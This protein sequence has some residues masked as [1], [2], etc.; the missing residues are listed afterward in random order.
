MGRFVSRDTWTGN[1]ANSTSQNRYSYVGGNP[2]THVDPSGHC[3]VDTFADIAFVGYDLLSLAFGPSKDRAD[4]WLAFGADA[5]AAALPCV[6][7]AGI[8]VRLASKA[9]DVLAR[10]FRIVGH[11]DP[12]TLEAARRELAGE[13]VSLTPSGRPFDTFMK[14]ETRKT[15][16]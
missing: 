10:L 14:S 8:I 13:I 5:G 1:L 15:D 16:C 4:N 12:R 11:I 6:T 9:D 7:G 3:F 2:T